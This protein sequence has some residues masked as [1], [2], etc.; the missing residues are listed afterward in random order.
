M[1]GSIRASA[2]TDAMSV[3]Y[4]LTHAEASAPLAPRAT[5]GEEVANFART[6][7]LGTA[8]ALIIAGML[9]VALFARALAPADPYRGDYAQQFAPPS[10]E[11]WF[12]TDEFGRDVLSRVMYGARIALFVGFA[13]SFAGCAVGGLL[14]VVSAYAGGGVDLLLERLM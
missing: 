9:F 7:P 2:T 13:A 1:R 5:L 3:N 4:P 11:H 14:G 8:G 6:K 10:A 12:G